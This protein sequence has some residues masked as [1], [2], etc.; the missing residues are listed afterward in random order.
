M[1]YSIGDKIMHPSHGAGRIKAIEEI[2]LVEG[3]DS[4]YMI[5]FEQCSMTLHIPMARMDELGVRPVMQESKLEK[6]LETLRSLPRELSDNYKTRQAGIREKLKTGRPLQ[7]AKAIRDLTWMQTSAS[8]TRGDEK[9]LNTAR[10]T[11]SQEIAL[12]HE[13]AQH[14]ASKLIDKALQSS[15]H[16]AEQHEMQP[17]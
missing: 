13:K 6:V 15:Q 1:E 2:E 7:V 10:E 17:A 14:E 8:L 4:Y 12:V 11:L 3:F 9:L 5:E 16:S